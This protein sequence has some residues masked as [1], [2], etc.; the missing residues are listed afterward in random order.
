[1]PTGFDYDQLKDLDALLHEQIPRS[2]DSEDAR[3]ARV[4]QSLATATVPNSG[5]MV[6][7]GPDSVG[8]D[9][10]VFLTPIVARQLV[11]GILLAGKDNDWWDADL[12]IKAKD[13]RL[14][15]PK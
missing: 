6:N 10:L 11:R 14:Y 9:R 5:I 2:P 1:M 12:N 13:G 4:P 8:K 15:S 7:F 3:T